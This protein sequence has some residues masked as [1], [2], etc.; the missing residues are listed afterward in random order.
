V[1]ATLP[2]IAEMAVTATPDE[3]LGQAVKAVI[4]LRD[5]ASLDERQ[6][7][8]HCHQRLASYKVPKVVEFA[9]EL[10]RTSTGKIQRFKLT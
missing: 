8:A 3:L 1:L 9:S 4:V 5:G 6:V 2:G 10:P 7:R